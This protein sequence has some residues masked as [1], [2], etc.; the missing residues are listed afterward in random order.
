MS[1]YAWNSTS[2]KAELTEVKTAILLVSQPFRWNAGSLEIASDNFA[3]SG[4]PWIGS[5]GRDWTYTGTISSGVVLSEQNSGFGTNTF[6]VIFSGEVPDYTT[7]FDVVL[8]RATDY[9][10]NNGIPANW[11]AHSPIASTVDAT[12]NIKARLTIPNDT[13]DAVQFAIGLALR[14]YSL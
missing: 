13:L 1:L 12:G 6:P 4:G 10:V 5:P 2:R 8:M 9:V 7:Q 14:G 11:R 3:G